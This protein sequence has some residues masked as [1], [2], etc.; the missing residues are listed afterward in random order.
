[1]RIEV[2]WVICFLGGLSVWASVPPEHW[3]LD[4]ATVGAVKTDSGVEIQSGTRMTLLRIE[5]GRVLGTFG[6]KGSHW[7]D[8]EKTN[9]ST[10]ADQIARGD[11]KKKCP[12]LVE[13]LYNNLF[14]RNKQGLNK[15]I[16]FAD[17]SDKKYFLFYFAY[18]ADEAHGSFISELSQQY[19]AI[20]QELP[21]LE[22]IMIQC[23]A[24][25]FKNADPK[26][27]TWPFMA[28][29]LS[30]AYKDAMLLGQ[31]PGASNFILT[32]S[33][34]NVIQRF[35]LDATLDEIKVALGALP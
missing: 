3:P 34:G 19:A 10:L 32:G 14:L 20:Q 8:L 15:P 22:L 33:N 29:H 9:V 6:R 35:E 21:S 1:M 7:I 30:H 25:V 28:V 26:N 13:R 5:E 16:R 24:L 2:Y 4:A 17:L 11:L 31:A 23:D 18:G 12:N 27:I